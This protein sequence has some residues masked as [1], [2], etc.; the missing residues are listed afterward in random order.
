[1]ENNEIQNL[2]T[3]VKDSIMR[4]GSL[5]KTSIGVYGVIY[6]YN[7]SDNCYVI[8]WANGMRKGENI[9]YDKKTIEHLINKEDWV[10]YTPEGLSC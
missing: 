7:H 6:K 2:V 8:S 10:Q 5:I 1:M 3:Y 9:S 4:V